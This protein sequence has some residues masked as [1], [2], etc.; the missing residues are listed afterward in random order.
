MARTPRHPLWRVTGGPD[1]RLAH[2]CAWTALLECL[3]D[4][5]R[6]RATFGEFHD[7]FDAAATHHRLS[8]IEF[9]RERESE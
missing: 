1:A 6:V 8:A 4:D 9:L 7:V 3:V 5:A 2:V